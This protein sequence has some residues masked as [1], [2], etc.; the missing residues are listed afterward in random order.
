MQWVSEV[1]T[2]LNIAHE[3]GKRQHIVSHSVLWCPKKRAKQDGNPSL[4]QMP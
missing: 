2:E 4:A 3:L 1:L